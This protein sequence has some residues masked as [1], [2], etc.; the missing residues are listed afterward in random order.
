VATGPDGATWSSTTVLS[1]S[2]LLTVS[3][4]TLGGTISPNAATGEL[5]EGL[6]P[7][8]W[9]FELHS[10]KNA[11]TGSPAVYNR[12]LSVLPL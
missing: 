1:G 6:K 9:T 5:A 2:N 12:V 10:R 11:G 3:S 8:A 4:G 7:G